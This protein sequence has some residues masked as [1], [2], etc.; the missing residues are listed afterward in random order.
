MK[1][2]I[3]PN[4]PETTTTTTPIRQVAAADGTSFVLTQDGNVY[5]SASPLV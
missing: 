4:G 3:S 2:P 1:G 5:R